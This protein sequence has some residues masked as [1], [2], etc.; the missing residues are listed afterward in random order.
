LTQLEVGAVLALLQ[1]LYFA[2]F[3]IGA[4]VNGTGDA[5]ALSGW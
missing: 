2:T 4:P 5:A 3:K 1:R